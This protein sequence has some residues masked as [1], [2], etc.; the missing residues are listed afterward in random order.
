MFLLY[1]K[2]NAKKSL[3]IIYEIRRDIY[4]KLEELFNIMSQDPVP[5]NKF[6]IKKLK[7]YRNY[8]RVRIGDIRV[9][10]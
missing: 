8:Y 7:G 2:K 3:K 10:Y 9:I 4:E 6:D 1:I 5:Y